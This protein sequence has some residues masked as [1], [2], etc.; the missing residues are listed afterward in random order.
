MFGWSEPFT[1]PQHVLIRS[2]TTGLVSEGLSMLQPNQ[3]L[4]EL[5]Q[6]S[7]FLCSSTVCRAEQQLFSSGESKSKGTAEMVSSIC[8]SA[9]IQ[10]TE[11][12][13]PVGLACMHIPQDCPPPNTEM[14]SA[15]GGR[16]GTRSITALR[17]DLVYGSNP[18]L[19]C[20]FSLI[21]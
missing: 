2:C 7:R 1:Q 18:V 8:R 13:V 10:T 20:S 16:P 6:P 5:L 3:L 19:L 4:S 11:S 12:S 21:N 17:F 15:Q 14:D 9:R